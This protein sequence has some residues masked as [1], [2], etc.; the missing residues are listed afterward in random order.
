MEEHGEHR[1]LVAGHWLAA[2]LAAL[3]APAGAECRLSLALGLD[4]SGSVDGREYRLQTGGLAG[5]L[6]APPVVEAILA[7]PGAPVEIAV[8]EW[9]GPE[10]QRLLLGWTRLETAGDVAAAAE[11]LR[12]LPRVP[13]RRPSTAI[14]AAMLYGAA[15]LA[16]RACWAR[17]IDLSGDGKSNTGPAPAPLR[18]D[19]RMAGIT[20]NAL[21]IG[22]D[23][24]GTA[25]RRQGEIAELSSYFRTQIIM[26]P[27]AFVETALG[28][29]DY[30]RAMTRK[31]LRELEGMAVGALGASGPPL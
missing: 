27:G 29:E 20:V 16:P 14:G 30:E 8:Y 4:I 2:L 18:R 28:F 24:R 25:D 5:A 21:V 10:S 6:T 26:G 12:G 23:D 9:A 17:A 3:A 13:T 1:A 19:A 11:A 31:L 15:L 22:A 7:M